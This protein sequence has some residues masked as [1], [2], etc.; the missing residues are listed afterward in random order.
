MVDFVEREDS[1]EFFVDEG[2]DDA[3]DGAGIP[4][5]EGLREGEAREG[6]CY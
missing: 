1:G 3:G 5:V 4:L 2:V 6:A